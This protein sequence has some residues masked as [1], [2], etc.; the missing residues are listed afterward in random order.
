MVSGIR[1]SSFIA[2]NSMEELFHSM[3]QHGRELLPVSRHERDKSHHF[4]LWQL[5]IK[6]CDLPL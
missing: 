2:W 3:E 1:L 4:L 6:M 5:H